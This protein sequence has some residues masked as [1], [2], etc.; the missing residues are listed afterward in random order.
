MLLQYTKNPK[1]Y[2]FTAPEMQTFLDPLN[3]PL[4]FLASGNPEQQTQ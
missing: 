3:F 4:P 2:S 1:T